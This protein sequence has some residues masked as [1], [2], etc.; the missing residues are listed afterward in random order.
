MALVLCAPAAPALAT[1]RQVDVLIRTASASPTRAEVQ[2]AVPALDVRAVRRIAP[3]TAVVV[4]RSAS[5]PTAVAALEASPA[6]SGASPDRRMRLAGTKAPVSSGATEASRQW[7]LWDAR[8]RKRAGGYGIDAARAWTRTLGSPSVVVAVLDTG[9]TAHP[10]LA[11]ASIAAG[12]DFVSGG[13]GT[14]SG[15]GD[16][17]DADPTDPGDA[18]ASAGASPSWHGTFV[19]GEIAARHGGGVIAGAAPGVTILPVRVLGACGGVESDTIA[20]ITW[21]SGGDVAGVPPPARRADVLS[22]SLGSSAGPCPAALQ[23]AV[24]G[25][26]ARGTTVVAA[27]G[28]DG[29]DIALSSPANCAGVISVAASTRSGALAAYSNRGVGGLAPTIAAPGGSRGDPILGAGWRPA[30]GGA[31]VPAVVGA[32]GTSMAAPYVASAAALLLSV[33]PGLAPDRVAAR[34]V[35]S[36]TRFP[37]SSGCVATICGAGIVN[38]GDAVGARGRFVLAG[39]V[40]ARGRA[41]PGEVLTARAGRWRP[42]PEVLRYRWLR[43]GA[44]IPGGT[45]RR[46]MLR[47]R[48]TG[49][50]IAVRVEVRR[51]GAA[52]ASAVSPARRVLRPAGLAP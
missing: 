29:D 1:S 3:H 12:Y 52:P 46:Y 9:I 14:A 34:L 40:A 17:W 32:V 19:T 49:H 36:A 47:A 28:N 42:A 43:D 35:R 26:I 18:C 38:A 2:R 10:A 27:A 13:D 25:A 44:A 5:S 45:G 23:A 41:E 24:D 15:D 16:G 22:M 37:A 20:A 33:Q 11:G 8:S 48:D 30:T 4:V 51:R 31:D 6:V 21:A 39:G 7:D 50:R